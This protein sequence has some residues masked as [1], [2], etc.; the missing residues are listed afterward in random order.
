MNPTIGIC[1]HTFTTHPNETKPKYVNFYGVFD[2]DWLIVTK[3]NK[4]D[5]YSIHVTELYEYT[6][7]DTYVTPD[8]YQPLP[9][10]TCAPDEKVCEQISAAHK[11][12]KEYYKHHKT[13]K[14]KKKRW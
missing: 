5:F 3:D 14:P 9:E 10:P 8:I 12:W 2:C 11:S 6:P 7:G 13:K 1:L 4:G